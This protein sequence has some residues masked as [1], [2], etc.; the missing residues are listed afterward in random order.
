[1]CQVTFSRREIEEELHRLSVRFLTIVP[2]ERAQD[3]DYVL[4]AGDD[5]GKQRQL[6][7]GRDDNLNGC[8]VGDVICYKGEG[9][10]VISIKRR[11][12]PPVTDA[13]VCRLALPHIR[14]VK[15]YEA[16]ITAALTADHGAEKMQGILTY[17]ARETFLRC[18]ADGF[19]EEIDWYLAYLVQ[20]YRGRAEMEQRSYEDL[21][22]EETPKSLNTTE[23]REAY[24]RSHAASESIHLAA[25]G[26]AL[27]QQNGKLVPEGQFE[28]ECLERCRQQG[29][30]PSVQ[31]LK[32]TVQLQQVFHYVQYF[33]DAVSA[34]METKFI[35]VITN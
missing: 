26:Y 20:Y 24:L 34:Y 29:R 8:R 1:M 4:L 9:A 6:L 11:I 14:T 5:G 32:Q 33:A 7:A 2:V 30:E 27:S 3:G 17:L 25:L 31:E 35:P 19:E 10:K 12:L 22:T 15:D 18:E 16:H 28:A 23:D 13:L 21:L